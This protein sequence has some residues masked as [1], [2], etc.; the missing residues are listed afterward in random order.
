MPHTVHQTNLAQSSVNHAQ[1]VPL[2]GLPL[3]FMPP[4]VQ[5][6][7]SQSS[8]NRT[9]TIPHSIPILKPKSFPCMDARKSSLIEDP[10]SIEKLKNIE[11]RLRAIEGVNSNVPIDAYELCLVP[12]VVIPPK[13]KVPVFNKYD[14]TT[15]PKSHLIMY[16]RKM[17]SCSYDDKLLIHFFQDS[18]TGPILRWYSRLNRARVRCWKDLADAFLLQYKYNIDMAPDR[19]ELQNME[20]KASKTF[21][22]YAQRWR[23]VAAQVE[24]P[25]SDKEMIAIFIDSLKPPFYDLIIGSTSSNFSYIFIVGEMVESAMRTRKILDNLITVNNA[26]KSLLKEEEGEVQDQP[27]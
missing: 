26:R 11:G 10:Q 24:P 27:E 6:Q 1:L 22:E 17:A 3:G 12:D 20:K 5:L 4:T 15:C 9:S 21:R 2:Y 19:L 16:Y 13:F 18:L 23:D 8:T 14:G 25:L 7:G